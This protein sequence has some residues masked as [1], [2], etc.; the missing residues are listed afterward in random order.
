MPL[1]PL[2]ETVEALEAIGRFASDDLV[3]EL[4]QAGALVARVVPECVGMSLALYREGLTFTLVASSAEVAALDGVQYAAGGPCVDAVLEDMLVDTSGEEGLLGEDRWATFARAGAA[5]GV[6][7]TLSMPLGS[8]G[9]VT[10]G[11]NFYAATPTAFEGRHEALAGIVGAWAPGAVMN[12]DLPFA[13]RAEAAKAPVRLRDQGTIDQ[14]V[15]YLSA[16]R[17]VDQNEAQAILAD[18]AARAGIPEVLVAKALLG[19]HDARRA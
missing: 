11:V 10:G 1:E 5:A 18:A 12:A 9:Q 4:R 17:K 19:A 7:S 13:S 6:L 2:P 3:A 15:G 16:L 8:A 14:A